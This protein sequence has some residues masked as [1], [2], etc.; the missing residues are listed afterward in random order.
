MAMRKTQVY[1]PAD[2][3]AALHKIARKQKRRVAELVRE[4]VRTV[5]LRP[6][7]DGPVKLWNGPFAGSSV[8]HDA[9]FDEL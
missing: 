9:A 6:A 1:L 7:D 4:A 5:W 8:D 3:L 2:E